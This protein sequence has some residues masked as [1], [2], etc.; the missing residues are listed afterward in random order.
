MYLLKQFFG[1]LMMLSLWSNVLALEVGQDA[2][3]FELFNQDNQRISLVE[4]RDQ[5]VVLYFYPKNETPGCVQEA[6]SFRDNMN[7]L[8]AQDA[9]VLG[10]SLDS[11]ASHQDFAK[12]HSLPFDLLSDE[13]GDVARSYGAL[14]DLKIFKFAKRHSFIIDPEGKLVKIYR[15][16]DPDTHVAEVLRDLKKLRRH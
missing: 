3:K 12:N 14:F 11:V 7:R 4:L 5:W 15:E 8:I 6:C 10:V 16:V 2:P 13:Q 1:G 9:K